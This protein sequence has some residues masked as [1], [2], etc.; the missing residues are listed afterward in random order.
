[1]RKSQ[2]LLLAITLLASTALGGCSGISYLLAN[3]APDMPGP[4]VPAQYEGLKD[5]TV[6]VV[7]YAD[8]NVRFEYPAVREELAGAINR[9]LEANLKK[10]VRTID[11]RQIVRYQ[12]AHPGWRGEPLPDVGKDLGADSVLYICLAEFATQARGSL[13]LPKGRI[14]GQASVW[15]VLPVK[16]GEDPCRWRQDSV[17]ITLEPPPGSWMDRQRLRQASQDVF[18]VQVVRYF[19]SYRMENKSNN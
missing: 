13:S 16:N 17:S 1:V 9:E 6:A 14:S 2:W 18:A 12:D 3:L 5:R 11:A 19:H 4:K 15:D 7:I 10:H 8:M